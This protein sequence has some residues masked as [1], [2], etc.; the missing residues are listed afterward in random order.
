MGQSV[1]ALCLSCC[2]S[3]V[4]DES[5]EVQ[6]KMRSV[7]WVPLESNPEIL[8]GFATKVGLPS[9]WEFVDV[10]GMD[11][12]LLAMVPPECVAVT[13]LFPCS[14]NLQRYKEQQ[15]QK[16]VAQSQTVSSELVYL[17]QYVNNACGTIACIHCLANNAKVIGLPSASPLGGFLAQIRELG[18]EAAGQLLADASELH[19]ASEASAVGGQTAAPQAAASVDHHFVAFVEKGGDVYELDGCKAFPVN[20]GPSEGDLLGAVAKI[21]RRCFMEPDPE[22]IHLNMMALVRP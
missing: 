1:Q 4:A 17:K 20:H 21:V 12:E 14:A 9:G 5:L 15:H 13:L 3:S 19:Q 8:N 22:N 7:H 18:P 11:P 16:I 2:G 10:L 6:A